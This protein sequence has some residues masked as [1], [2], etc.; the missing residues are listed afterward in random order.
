VTLETEPQV[1]GRITDHLTRERLRLEVRRARRP[2]M[3]WIL[4]IVGALMAFVLLL[5]ELHLPA[6]WQPQYTIQIAAPDVTGV[7]A[8]D[9]VRIAGVEVGHVTGIRLVRDVPVLTATIDPRYEPLYRN[10]QVQIR[11]N[12]PLQ[13]MFVDIVSPGTRA[14]GI[15]RSGDQLPASQVESPVQIGQVIDIFDA[16]VRPRVTAAIN[17]LG[18]GLGY[19]GLQLREALVQLAPFLQAAQA[20]SR[21]I[22]VRQTETEQLVHN[23]ALL[24][25]ALASRSRQLT[26]LVRN[27]A[28]T[29]RSIASAS[30]PLGQFIDQLP[31]TL[32]ELPR[33]FAAVDAAAGQIDPAARALLPVA[34]ALAP[35]LDALRKLSPV[36]TRA[37]VALDRPLPGL[38]SLLDW[39]RPLAV[40][41]DTAFTRL[42]P[43]A[44]E[45]NHVTSAIVPCESAITD[46]FQWTLST[47]KIGGPHGDM[48]R[49][50]AIFSPSSFTDFEAP[51]LPSDTLVA[52]V[53]PTCAHFQETFP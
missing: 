24:N 5:A 16:A 10:A 2:F 3:W 14:A 1:R 21:E 53:A 50:M 4:L 36:A 52:K 20:L 17:A 32:R 9:E 7:Q 43:Q 30:G 49:G 18:Q 29:M 34:G 6:P 23:F 26:G 37:L 12:T 25:Q 27:G 11:P 40:N 28:A 45:L 44:P 51:S 42:L 33:S 48:Q 47:S 41:L 8:N 35:A 15:L 19:H 31:P 39:S 13:D 46:F 38:T 22:A